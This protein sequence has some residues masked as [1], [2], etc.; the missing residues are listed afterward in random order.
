MLGG[1]KE[2]GIILV[3][4]VVSY[5]NGGVTLIVPIS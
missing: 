5:L 4:Y 2:Q 3:V 1:I